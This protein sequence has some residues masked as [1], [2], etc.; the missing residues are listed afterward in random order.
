MASSWIPLDKK[1]MSRHLRSSNSDF[2]F[3][4]RVGSRAFSIAVPTP[5]NSL[6]D[7]VKLAGSD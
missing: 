2:L 6:P 7:N 3:T 1:T 4:S 5:W